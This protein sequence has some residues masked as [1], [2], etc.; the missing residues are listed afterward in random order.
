MER[1]LSGEL[2]T[3]NVGLLDGAVAQRGTYN[4][5]IRG[6]RKHFEV[7]LDVLYRVLLLVMPR[8]GL[9]VEDSAVKELL[10]DFH[11]AVVHCAVVAGEVV[12][13]EA[14]GALEVGGHADQLAGG[15]LVLAELNAG[16]LVELFGSLDELHRD[17]MLGGAESKEYA[18]AELLPLFFGKFHFNIHS[19]FVIRLRESHKE[20]L[21]CVRAVL[22]SLLDVAL[23]A[24]IGESH[25]G[26]IP[27]PIDL[28]ILV[29]VVGSADELAAVYGVVQI[30]F[31]RPM[32]ESGI[33][34]GYFDPVVMTM[35]AGGHV[36]GE[37]ALHRGKHTVAADVSSAGGVVDEHKIIG[38]AGAQSVP[39]L[40][41][42]AIPVIR[43]E[44]LY[45]TDVLLHL[46]APFELAYALFEFFHVSHRLYLFL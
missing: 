26:G 41:V 7:G 40:L 25:F 21:I 30:V 4:A 17:G 36:V 8:G 42:K 18:V 12:G 35:V 1:G 6:L 3:D 16:D 28:D 23:T 45:C 19:I 14:E 37:L 9:L 39:I 15:G 33:F 46:N 44:T 31:E 24:K 27:A 34:T 5:G 29:V 10:V 32:G 38:E 13:G 11:A 2:E 43:L 20:N 22:K